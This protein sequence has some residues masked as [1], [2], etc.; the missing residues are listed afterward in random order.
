[1]IRVPVDAGVA[2]WT[3]GALEAPSIVR[4]RVPRSSAKQGIRD[5]SYDHQTGDSRRRRPSGYAA[6]DYPES[7]FD[8]PE[9]DQ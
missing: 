9:S 2:P 4:A 8:Y 3:I 7:E 5:I 6:F 1:V